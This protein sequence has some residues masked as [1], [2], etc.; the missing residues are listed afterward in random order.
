MRSH[1]YTKRS[2]EPLDTIISLS[3][4]SRMSPTSDPGVKY[5]VSALNRSWQAAEIVTC[6]VNHTEVGERRRQGNL[7]GESGT[8][9]AADVGQEWNL[10]ARAIISSREKER[11]LP[12]HT[13][14]KRSSCKALASAMRYSSGRLSLVKASF[15][16]RE[17]RETGGWWLLGRER[18]ESLSQLLL[19]SF[20]R[21]VMG[22]RVT[23]LFSLDDSVT[24]LGTSKS[25]WWQR[26]P[27][28]SGTAQL[29]ASLGLARLSVRCCVL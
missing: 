20:T 8:Y 16:W 2:I 25:R 28:S 27:P 5:C 11:A 13:L 29:D 14:E 23:A 24:Q 9:A 21:V 18:R 22:D 4:F 10:R 19:I 6:I 15:F 12:P 7:G 1:A 26:Q 17:R 3:A